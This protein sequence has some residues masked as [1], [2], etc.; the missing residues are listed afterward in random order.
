M[1]VPKLRAIRRML[2]RE[3]E[4]NNICID[5]GRQEDTQ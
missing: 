3:E 4:E 2:K 5:M 1:E